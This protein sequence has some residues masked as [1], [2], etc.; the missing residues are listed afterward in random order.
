MIYI[1]QCLPLFIL[2]HFLRV[3]RLVLLAILG[4][5]L[6]LGLGL[7]SLESSFSRAVTIANTVSVFFFFI[8]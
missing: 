4:G 3:S 8:P 1:M 5:Y 6:V 7:V 2:V